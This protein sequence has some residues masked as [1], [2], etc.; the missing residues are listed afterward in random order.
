VDCTET[1]INIQCESFVLSCFLNL[2]LTDAARPKS[3]P[4]LQLQTNPS[5]CV[6]FSGSCLSPCDST[7][8]SAARLEGAW[9]LWP[10]A[11]EDL[12]GAGLYILLSQNH[13]ESGVGAP[14]T[15]AA[16]VGRKRE[17]LPGA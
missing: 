15:A 2:S 13:P 17:E 5:S 10:C 3:L 6:L 8:S 12:E 14:S 4:Q 7:Y 16:G 1:T 11:W 9:W